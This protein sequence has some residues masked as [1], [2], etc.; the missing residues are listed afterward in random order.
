MTSF[1]RFSHAIELRK[2]GLFD[3]SRAVLLSLIGSEVGN[4]PV[5]LN[6]AWSYD[7]QGLEK[8]AMAYY[9]KSLEETL[10]ED[11]YFEAKF[12]LACTY[13]C[14]GYF[15]EAEPLFESLIIAYPE[16]TEV[17]PFLVLCLISV[18]KKDYA[19]RILLELVAKN[20]PTPGILAYQHTLLGYLKEL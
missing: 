8:R 7:N 17:V 20:P 10:S 14:L 12:G 2:K 13:R 18:E 19:L 4:G 6:I 9:I 11:D 16:R 3:E 5:Y 1:Q 15:K